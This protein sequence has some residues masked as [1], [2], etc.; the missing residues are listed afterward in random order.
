MVRTCAVFGCS[1]NNKVK[2][3]G[4][5]VK[6]EYKS[7]FK[8]PYIPSKTGHINALLKFDPLDSENITY[9]KS[10]TQLWVNAMSNAKNS[11]VI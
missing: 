5:W 4:I 7:C 9:A 6:S 10:I 2:K 3:N 11:I 1:T 8:F